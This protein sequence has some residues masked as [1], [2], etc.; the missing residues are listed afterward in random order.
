[1]P[2]VSISVWNWVSFS[3]SPDSGIF[4]VRNVVPAM[5]WL[6]VWE[7]RFTGNF[8]DESRH[9][10]AICDEACAR[11]MHGRQKIASRVVDACDVAHV[12][13]DFFARAGSR[14]PNLFRFAN[15]GATQS[16]CEFQSASL[17]VLME[18]D[19]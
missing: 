4:V 15:P 16:A 5:L 14:A 7:R 13:L 12:N 8:L 10:D 9:P 11:A 2:R 18:H 17:I 1:M 19:S 3:I 6:G